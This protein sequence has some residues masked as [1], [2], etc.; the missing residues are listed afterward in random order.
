MDGSRRLVFAVALLAL[1]VSCIAWLQPPEVVPAMAPPEMFSA[2]R[3]R[4]HLVEIAREPRP[5]G[6]PANRR[7]REHLLAT[8]AALGVPG[9]VQS[10]SVLSTRWGVPYDAAHVENVVAR[11]PG[12][13]NTRAIALVA[14][15]D[16]VPGSPG[17]GDDGAAVAALL[18]ALRALRSGGPLRNDVLFLFTDGEEGGTLGAKAFVDEH[19]WR[20]DLGLALN[21]DARGA[22][23]VVAMFE[24]GP[25]NGWLIRELAGSAPRPVAS[26]LFYEV[27]RRMG[28]STDFAELKRAGIPGMN[29]AFGDRA[30]HYHAPTDTVENLDLR[31]VQHQGS[32]ALS[33]ARRF[34]AMNLREA[35]RERREGSF[36]VVYFNAFGAQLVSYPV[37]WALSIAALVVLLFAAV[38]GVSVKRGAAGALRIGGG[39]VAFVALLAGTGAVVGALIQLVRRVH[40]AL[41]ATAFAPYDTTFYR[42]AITLLSLAVAAA[43]VRLFRRRLGAVELSLGALFVWLVLAVAA[44]VSAP[45]ASGVFVWPLASSLLGLGGRRAPRAL[46]GSCARRRGTRPLPALR[47]AGAP[48]GRARGARRRAGRRPLPAASGAPGGRAPVAA[49]ARIRALRRRGAGRRLRGHPLHRGAPPADLPGLRARQRGGQG[50]VAHRR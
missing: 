25:E 8:L 9:E 3:A 10:A 41:R 48:A 4:A 17:A 43:L 29:F 35:G 26:S 33:L 31:S 49:V 39:A 20:G 38:A 6:T 1:V 30:A 14:H 45:R 36:D 11:L 50:V 5:T 12:T 44:S 32:Y 13:D 23:G 37:S 47:R 21:F 42:L 15:Y 7:A 22:G 18:E 16:S 27:A 19:R 40:P 24:T 46:R 2:E 28:H 34:G